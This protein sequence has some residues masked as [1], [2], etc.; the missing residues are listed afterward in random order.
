M[1]APV[2]VGAVAAALGEGLATAGET[3]ALAGY[4][5]SGDSVRAAIAALAELEPLSLVDDGETLVLTAG[6]G[7]APVDAR[8]SRARRG[9][10]RGGRAQ[11]MAAA[12][13]RLRARPRRRWLITIRA[14]TIRPGCSGRPGPGRR[15]AAT[16]APSPAALDAGDRQGA[17]G[18]AARAAVGRAALGQAASRLV[19]P[20]AGGR[21]AR[22]RI[23]GRPGLWKVERWTLDRMVLTLELSGVPAGAPAAPAEASAGRPVDQPDLAARPDHAAPAR[24][25]AARRGA[26]EPAAAAGRGGGRGAGLAPGR[27]ERQLRRRR[28]LGG[29]R[30]DRA[31][32]VIG[33]ALE[34]SGAGRLRPV[35]RAQQRRG[36]AAQRGD[37]AG[38]PE[39]RRARRRRQSRGARRR[40]DP[41]RRSASRS[42][43]G[44]S[45]CRGCCAGGGGPNGPPACHAAG[46]PFA[47]IEAESL[48]AIDAPLGALGGEARLL[49]TGLGDPDG[50]PALRPGRAG[51]AMRPPSP[52][53][54][55]ARAAAERRP[56]AELGQA[57]PQ[58]L[59]VAER[60]R[61]AARRGERSLS[62]DAGRRR[63]SS[64]A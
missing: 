24:P 55:R 8:G 4:A 57:Q 56:R 10:G 45:G 28:Q 26:A 47:L 19:P 41:V 44:A 64:G 42:A 17:G 7:A 62:A 34:R 50:V 38:E 43:S 35:R 30:S 46:E 53:H 11:R 48:A 18:A 2:S 33:T 3:A 37:V 39:R 59:G 15:S 51:E 14:A 31:A 49:A 12:Q 16:G 36:R 5:A 27:A 21:A 60:Q 1:P 9:G 52:V 25:A 29:G 20:R 13:R 58:R 63:A 54:L 40:A 6:G 22:V 23:G 32:G 61:H